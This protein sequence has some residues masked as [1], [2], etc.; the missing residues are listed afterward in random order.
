MNDMV[1]AHAGVPVILLSGMAADERLFEPQRAILPNIHVAPWIKPWPNESLRSYAHRMA[2]THDPGCRCLVGGASFGGT[3]ALEMAPLLRA[4]A[5]LLIGSIRSSDELPWHW[6]ALRPLAM[7]GPSGLRVMA[8]LARAAAPLLA[9]GTARRLARLARP[10]AAFV[11]WAMCA[12]VRWRPSPAARRV[13]VFQIHGSADRT[14]PIR[15]TR[16]DVVIP[17]G[18][19]DLPL[20]NAAAVTQFIRQCVERVG[21]PH[22][23]WTR[24]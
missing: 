9:R 4:E 15:H 1:N 20:T 24:R 22:D 17:G 23:A 7:L 5:C 6:R 2:R 14:L 13:R 18:G 19:H 11:R 10:E 12:V 3:V 16:P 8:G 21:T